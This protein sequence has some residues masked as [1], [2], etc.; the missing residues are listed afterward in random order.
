VD[1]RSS[2][3]STPG[4][5]TDHYSHECG[6]NLF[7]S[8]GVRILLTADRKHVTQSSTEQSIFRVADAA[9]MP[10]RRAA[11]KERALLVIFST[12]IG[13]VDMARIMPDP[14]TREKVLRNAKDFLLRSF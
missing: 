14:V 2:A 13:A 12:L 7:F 11:D 5:V 4:E 8:A 6:S 1:Y 10:G 9:F 3:Q